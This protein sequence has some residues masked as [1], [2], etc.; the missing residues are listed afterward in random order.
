MDLHHEWFDLS[1][2]LLL[3]LAHDVERDFVFVLGWDLIIALVTSLF[4]DVW[5]DVK[6]FF[7]TDE[8]SYLVLV[9]FDHLVFVLHEFVE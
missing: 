9:V 5:D 7:S 1:L 8:S 6:P 2:I 4:E 3:Q